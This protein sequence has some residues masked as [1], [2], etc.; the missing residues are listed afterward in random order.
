MTQQSLGELI[1]LNFVNLGMQLQA[2]NGSDK[3]E[4]KELESFLLNA[5]TF[6]EEQIAVINKA[7]KAINKWRAKKGS[8][9]KL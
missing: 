5:P 1:K 3:D 6:S 7:L 4:L 9:I 8:R 2:D